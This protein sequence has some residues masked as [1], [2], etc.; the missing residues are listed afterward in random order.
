[1]TAD[2]WLL[3]EICTGWLG[4]RPK[5]DTTIQVDAYFGDAEEKENLGFGC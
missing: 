5:L 1:M 2:G 3:L 4:D